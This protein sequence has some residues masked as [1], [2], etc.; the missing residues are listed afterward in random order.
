[1]AKSPTIAGAIPQ[2]YYDR[3][4]Q[5][6]K[7]GRFR[8]RSAFVEHAVIFYLDYLE[9]QVISEPECGPDSKTPEGS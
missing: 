6:I 1:M 3:V 5:L 9:R 7:E 4:M 2:Y 8:N